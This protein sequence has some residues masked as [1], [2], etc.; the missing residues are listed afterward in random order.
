MKL[1]KLMKYRVCFTKARLAASI[2]IACDFAVDYLVRLLREDGCTVRCDQVSE[3]TTYGT[4]LKPIIKK[5][6]GK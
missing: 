5:K 2:D 6:K 1:E 3:S 4:D